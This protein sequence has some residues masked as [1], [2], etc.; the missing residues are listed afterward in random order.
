MPAKTAKDIM[1][2][3]VVTVKP[4][5]SISDAARL[6]VSKKI[7]GV[8]VVDEKDKT[9]VVGILTEADLLAAP[10]GAKTVGDVMKKRVVSVCPDTTVEEIA[11][12][13]VKKKIKRVPVIDAGKLVGIVSRIDVL[14]AKYGG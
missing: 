4:S 12:L 5:T 13:L 2:T 7:S 6:L 10:A 3:K 11:N 1:T 9:K 14:R 8:P